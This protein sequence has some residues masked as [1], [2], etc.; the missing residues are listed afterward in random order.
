MNITKNKCL[1]KI[2]IQLMTHNP[3]WLAQIYSAS[4][5]KKSTLQSIQNIYYNLALQNKFIDEDEY[6]KQIESYL[7]PTAPL[8]TFQLSQLLEDTYHALCICQ[9]EDLAYCHQSFFK[10]IQEEIQTT[11]KSHFKDIFIDQ[12]SQ[13]IFEDWLY[14]LDIDMHHI[15]ETYILLDIIKNIRQNINF[16]N[17]L[18]LKI[19]LICIEA[20]AYEDLQESEK[21]DTLYQQSI[22]KY[23]LS[24]QLYLNHSLT[25]L[26]R[27]TQFI[28][29]TLF[30][31][32]FLTMCKNS[33]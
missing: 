28:E 33:A 29:K 30:Q 32:Y 21:C 13:D 25:V 31:D 24:N 10:H 11:K 2:K 14:E 9:D 3:A 12:K 5:H 20:D 8:P 7:T 17:H 27:H 6:K 23:P 16:S 19:L 4:D 26:E 1:E 18:D 15:Q 22:Q